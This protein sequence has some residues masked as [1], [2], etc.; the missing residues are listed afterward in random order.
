MPNII[1]SNVGGD[2]DYSVNFELPSFLLLGDLLSSLHSPFDN[3]IL[4]RAL[5]NLIAYLVIFIRL[6]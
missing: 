2:A 4:G 3:T 5:R 1:I 6:Y